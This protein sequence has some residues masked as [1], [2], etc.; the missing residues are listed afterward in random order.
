MIF[1][2]TRNPE[3]DARTLRTLI[4]QFVPLRT[5]LTSTS[6]DGDSFSTTAKTKIDLSSVFSAPAKVRAVL[7]N[8]EIN[9]SGSA[10]TD[11]YLY[12]GPD[13]TADSGAGVTCHP[14]NDRVTRCQRWVTCDASGDIY[15]QIAASG[16][17]TMD[18][19]LEIAGYLL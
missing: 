19:V 7:A 18:V 12:L 9:D 5:A 17:S 8:I 14:T 16:A 13:D 15:Y 10:G 4:P 2:G 11:C 1:L 3:V 6:W